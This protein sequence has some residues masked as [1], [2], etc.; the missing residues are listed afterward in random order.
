MATKTTTVNVN[1]SLQE[2]A[3]AQVKQEETQR[4]LGLLPNYYTSYIWD[5]VPMTPKSKFGMAIRTVTD[6]VLVLGCRWNCRSGAVPQNFPRVWSGSG[7]VRQTIWI[8]L[9]GHSHEQDVG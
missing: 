1:A 3:E 5:A 2:V 9:C 8:D 6:P 7:R 4:L